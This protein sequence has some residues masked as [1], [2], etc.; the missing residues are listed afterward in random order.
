MPPTEQVENLQQKQIMK[1]QK[2]G[3]ESEFDE[4]ESVDDL[5]SSNDQTQN[6]NDN[7]KQLMFD[8]EGLKET[9]LVL[10]IKNQ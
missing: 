5:E 4:I 9:N 2:A 6:N 3:H 8:D 10:R 7:N 1:E